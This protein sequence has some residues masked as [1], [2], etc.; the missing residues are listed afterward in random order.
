MKSDN[1]GAGC[2]LFLGL[3]VALGIGFLDCQ[4][5]SNL[6]LQLGARSWPKVVATVDS[7]RVFVDDSGDGVSYIPKISYHY[8][9][10]GRSYVGDRVRWGFNFTTRK[11]AD[12]VVAT[13]PVGGQVELAVNPANP[14]ESVLMQ[15]LEP[16]D[17]QAVLFLLPFNCI[18]LGLLLSPWLLRPL[19]AGYP[20]SRQRGRLYL[21]I[22]YR[23][24]LASAL[25]AIFGFS[26][27]TV[28]VNAIAF[29]M[30]VTTGV[31]QL[32]FLGIGLAGLVAAWKAFQS[33]HDLGRA[34]EVDPRLQSISLPAVGR[35]T[36]TEITR[37]GVEDEVGRDSDGDTTHTF[38]ITMHTPTGEQQRIH[39]AGS[40]EV[41]ERA[42][43]WLNRAADRNL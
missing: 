25:L 23:N 2:L 41:A 42:A 40:Q 22:H 3:L 8:Q 11:W 18:A 5:G 4:I 6:R 32:E 26:F 16:G 21:H 9:V 36:W 19:A 24:P 31:N 35:R 13:R 1:V 30:L 10:E 39:K 38:W 29:R 33:N 27:A 15:G 20:E 37:F 28:F 12:Q 17:G 34:V 14:S 43:Q 7:S